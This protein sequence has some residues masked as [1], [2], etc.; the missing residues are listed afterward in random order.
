MAAMPDLASFPALA[1]FGGTLVTAGRIALYVYAALATTATTACLTL[2]AVT[3]LDRRLLTRRERAA[4]RAGARD[5][6]RPLFLK[7]DVE[8]R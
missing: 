2:Y 7:L 8:P 4:L 5:A 3:R 1:S 6:A